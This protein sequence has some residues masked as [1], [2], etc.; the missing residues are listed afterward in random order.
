M[1]CC[2]NL[3]PCL[4]VPSITYVNSYNRKGILSIFMGEEHETQ[5][6][7]RVAPLVILIQF[8]PSTPFHVVHGQGKWTRPSE[9]CSGFSYIPAIAYTRN[10]SETLF[11]FILHAKVFS[12]LQAPVLRSL[13]L[14]S[15]PGPLPSRILEVTPSCTASPLGFSPTCYCCLLQGSSLLQSKQKLSEGRKSSLM[16]YN[17]G[18]S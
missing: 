7:T 12:L 6:T 1:W 16:D 3:N 5:R 2:V 9:V 13:P 10:P 11:P 17:W 8:P 14:W 15:L 4:R 18:Q